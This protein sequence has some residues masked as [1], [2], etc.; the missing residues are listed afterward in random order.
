MSECEMTSKASG[1]KKMLLLFR[2]VLFLDIDCCLLCVLILL[3]LF[4]LKR[5]YFIKAHRAQDV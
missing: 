5:S 2:P 4:C 3:L 1:M